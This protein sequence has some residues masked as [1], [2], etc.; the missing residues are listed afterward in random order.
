MDGRRRLALGAL[1]LLCFSAALLLHSIPTGRD[2]SPPRPPHRPVPMPG[3][4]PG[5]GAAPVPATPPG[6]APAAPPPAEPADPASPSPSPRV[7]EGV[8]V[9]EDGKSPA[10]VRVRCRAIGGDPG[11]K[12]GAPREPVETDPATGRFRLETLPD[13]PVAIEASPFDQGLGMRT[14]VTAGPDAKEVRIVLRRR[15][16]VHF[17]VVDADTGEPVR[18]DGELR[19][20]DLEGEEPLWTWSGGVGKEGLEQNM[21]PGVLHR[22]RAVADEYLPGEVVEVSLP[23]GLRSLEVRLALRKDPDPTRLALEFTVDSGALPASVGVTHVD[24]ESRNRVRWWRKKPSRPM[25]RGRAT[26]KYLSRPGR[27]A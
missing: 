10:Y 19:E 20:V 6:P 11:A 3:P 14:E 4:A 2:A 26:R 21:E 5:P 16:F 24:P 27:I 12:E 13:G 8:V 9:A 25:N 1:L 17:L 22:F 23:P 18:K 15:T 7:L